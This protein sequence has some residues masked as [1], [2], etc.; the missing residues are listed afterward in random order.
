MITVAGDRQVADTAGYRGMRL[1]GQR[2]ADGNRGGV[3]AAIGKPFDALPQTGDSDAVNIVEFS[4]V[5]TDSL[6]LEVTLQD[7]YSAGV[8]EWRIVDAR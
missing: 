4:P 5:T 7:G 8:L 3:E 6:R 2:N 1:L